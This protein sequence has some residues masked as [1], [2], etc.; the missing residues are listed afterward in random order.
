MMCG[1]LVPWPGV[2]PTSPA[3]QG[4]FL[5][6][7]PPGKSLSSIFLIFAVLVDEKSSIF[8]LKSG[9]FE[10]RSKL[11]ALLVAYSAHFCVLCGL[12]LPSAEYFTQS[13]SWS[14]VTHIRFLPPL[15]STPALPHRVNPKPS[16]P[17][18]SDRGTK[19]VCDPP[20]WF[21]ESSR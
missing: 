16:S 4:R 13:G 6:T 11:T 9:K 18:D 7:G 12:W 1:V 2:E 19:R 8:Y 20:F 10:Y 15:P 3:L 21:A 14:S 5:T 17:Q